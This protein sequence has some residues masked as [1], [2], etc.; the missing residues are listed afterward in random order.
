VAGFCG[1]LANPGSFGRECGQEHI[2]RNQVDGGAGKPDA[3]GVGETGRVHR[4][5]IVISGPGSVGFS[6]V[7]VRP[8]ALSVL[9][10]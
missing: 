2:R 6:C 10:I 8:G 5:C 9:S 4:V 1:W 3:A 7:T